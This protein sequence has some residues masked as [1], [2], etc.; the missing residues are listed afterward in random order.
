VRRTHRVVLVTSA[1]AL[2]ATAPAGSSVARVGVRGWDE[3]VLI[4]KTQAS[5]EISLAVNPREERQLAVCGPSGFPARNGQ[6]YFHRTVDGGRTWSYLDIE[7]APADTRSVALEGGD[8]DVAYDAGG[9]LWTADTWLGSLSI[10][11]SRDGRAFEGTALSTPVPIVD[12]PWIA[13]GPPGTLYV[14]YQDLQALMPSVV[15]F[16]KT[17]DYGKTFTPPV[18]VVTATADGAYTWEGNLVV[19]NGGKDLYLAYVRR[20]GPG[21]MR[22]PHAVSLAA[23]HDGGATWTSRPIARISY[24]TFYPSLAIDAGGYLH[25]VWAEESTTGANPVVY[26]TSKDRGATWSRPR[27]LNPGG[28]STAPWVA[29]GRKG[30][31]RIV[32]LGG[33]RGAVGEKY[34]YYAKVDDGRTAAMGPTTTRPVWRGSEP[35]PEFEMVRLD[36]RGRMHVAM[37][38]LHSDSW[39]DPTDSHSQWAFYYQ[40]ESRGR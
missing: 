27:P 21:H 25:V 3:P 36:K 37:A 7:T 5:V 20:D 29:G 33:G 22:T 40:R 24:G 26:T 30:E 16:T 4:S 8:C 17:T 15:W 1:V 19:A 14:T 13:G 18:A 31:A 32:W 11:H 35:Y 10:G 34:F 23:S 38:V 9:T 12:R 28:T 39:P 6:S 2:C